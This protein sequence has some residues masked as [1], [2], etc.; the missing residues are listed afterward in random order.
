MHDG[1]ERASESTPIINLQDF[2]RA[3]EVARPRRAYSRRGAAFYRVSPYAWTALWNEGL[4]RTRINGLYEQTH[5][6]PEYRLSAAERR[7]LHVLLEHG[8]VR[9]R[10]EQRAASALWVAQ[11]AGMDPSR[12]GKV[13][14]RLGGCGIVVD[15][16]GYRKRGLDLAVNSDLYAW[17]L[18]RLQKLRKEVSREISRQT[19][20]S[21]FDVME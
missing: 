3:R 19:R 18:E 7:V 14:R 12:A 15:V 21:D 5:K 11:Q 4:V 9:G 16:A 20:S 17:D 6:G 13:L 2:R 10:P 8:A 1:P